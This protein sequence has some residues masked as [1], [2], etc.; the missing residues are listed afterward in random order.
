MIELDENGSY[1]LS[2]DYSDDIQNVIIL[3]NSGKAPLNDINIRKT[4]MHAINKNK[5][6]EDNLGGLFEPVYN[7]FPRDAPFSDV[8]LNPKWDYDLET[9]RFLNC[10]PEK[11]G[12]PGSFVGGGIKLLTDVKVQLDRDKVRVFFF[13]SPFLSVLV[14]VNVHYIYVAYSHHVAYKS[15]P[16]FT[17]YDLSNDLILLTIRN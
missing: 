1:G 2:V 9:A 8:D 5:I 14:L 11:L 10:N 12:S 3:L 17:L 16:F 4:I 6:T 7:V 15:Y 13:P